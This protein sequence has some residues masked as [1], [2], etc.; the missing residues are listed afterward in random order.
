M[1]ESAVQAKRVIAYIDGF[2]LY[3]G[4]KDGGWQRYYW[5]NVVSLIEKLAP[6][7]AK[8]DKV[9]YFT[10]KVTSPEPKRKRQTVY[11]E[12][13]EYGTSCEIIYGN[14]Q[15]EAIYCTSCAKPFSVQKEKMTDVNIAVEMMKDAFQDN[16]DIAILVSGD[17]DLTPPVTTVIK[18]F[19][20]KQVIIRFPPNRYSNDLD[21]QSTNSNTITRVTLRD[22][23]LPEEVVKPDGYKLTRPET[24]K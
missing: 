4:L 1:C 22:S 11:L 19:P 8:I 24:W 9:K 15:T 18:L 3:F 13:L 17:S 7:D 10:A 23:Q 16:F 21:R 5:L 12:A 2:N 20:Q 6:S 14:Y